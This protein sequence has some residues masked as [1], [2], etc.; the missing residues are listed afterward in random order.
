MVTFFS[1][2]LTANHL[3]TLRVALVPFIY[4]GMVFGKD[5]QFALHYSVV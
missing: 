1:K 2:W 4:L 3:T 5:D